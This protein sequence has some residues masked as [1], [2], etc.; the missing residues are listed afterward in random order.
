MH[1]RIPDMVG[2][3]ELRHCLIPKPKRKAMRNLTE[4]PPKKEDRSEKVSR[5]IRQIW[6]GQKKYSGTSRHEFHSFFSIFHWFL[7]HLNGDATTL[8][9]GG[10]KKAKNFKPPTED[11]GQLGFEPLFL[12]SFFG[13]LWA[14]F[15]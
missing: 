11:S 15:G 7:F 6:N 5:C 13:H 1:G 3:P 10:K 2:K 14:L 4:S 8:E 9:E 12:A